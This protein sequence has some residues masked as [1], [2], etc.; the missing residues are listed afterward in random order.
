MNIFNQYYPAHNSTG[1]TERNLTCNFAEALLAE[2]GDEA[3][4]AS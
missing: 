1:F 2:L 3:G 4:L